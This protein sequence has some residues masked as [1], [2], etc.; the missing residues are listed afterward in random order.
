MFIKKSIRG[1]VSTYA[2]RTGRAVS[3]Y[4]KIFHTMSIEW[5][6]FQKLGGIH[7]IGNSVSI[8]IVCP[9]TGRADVKIANNVGIS[10][11][12]LLGHDAVV[13]KLNER[14][15]KQLGSVG[16]I[17]ICDNSFIGHGAIYM[18]RV[19]IG[20][21]SVVAAGAVVTK[22]VPPGVVVGGN[23][24]R[25]IC[26]TEELLV[27]MEARSDT[28]PCIYLVRQRNGPYDAAMEPTLKQM[29]VQHFFGDSQ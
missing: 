29:R 4:K 21:D 9:V 14:L 23:P 11:A 2:F 16:S 6:A 25:I 26:A 10:N 3:A 22:D 20:F 12:T 28:C 7:S 5:G 15:G 1:A 8:D 17:K 24:A 27:R 19:K 18:H 13:R